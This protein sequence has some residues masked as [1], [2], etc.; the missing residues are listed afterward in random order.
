MRDLSVKLLLAAALICG[1]AA[2][3]WA[4]L[5]DGATAFEAGDYATALKEWRPLAEQDDVKALNLIRAMYNAGT[6]VPKNY[7]KVVK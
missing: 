5:D 4:D 1:A 2:P 7:A 3:A 6:D